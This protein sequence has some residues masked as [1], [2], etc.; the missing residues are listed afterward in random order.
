MCAS[1]PSGPPQPV[2]R[3]VSI[4]FSGVQLLATL[5]LLFFALPF[6]DDLRYGD[7]IEV[8]LLSVVMLSAVMVLRRR[9]GVWMIALTLL[10]AALAGKWVGYFWPDLL[11][12]PVFL[13]TYLAFFVFV[14]VHFLG[15]I[16]RSTRVDADALCIGLSGYL[17]LGLMWTPV[18]VLLGHLS[19]EAFT[20]N[21]GPAADQVMDG[22]N[23]F[24]Y[25]F[26]TLCTIGFGDIAPISRVARMVTVIE[27]ISG[28]FYVAVLISRLVAIYS[29]NAAATGIPPE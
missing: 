10:A 23:A 4:R 26:V 8:T 15:L 16:L 29:S 1:G 22:F 25:S 9:R 27:A 3:A 28:L 14:A 2:N 7:L 13:A 21:T 5:L 24:Y 17:I 20:F 11:P 18:Y 19:P 12:P 6:V